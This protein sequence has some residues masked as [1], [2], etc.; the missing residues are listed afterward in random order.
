MTS[1]SGLF[2]LC[3]VSLRGLIVADLPPTRFNR[4]ASKGPGL[5]CNASSD[6]SI[7][8]ASRRL[9]EGPELV[10]VAR[11]SGRSSVVTVLDVRP[12]RI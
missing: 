9:Y 6:K 4:T 1:G 5:A 7:D 3:S 2:S 12:H 10:S 11:L 8:H